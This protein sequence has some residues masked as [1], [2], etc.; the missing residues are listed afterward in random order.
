MELNNIMAEKQFDVKLGIVRTLVKE[1]EEINTAPGW[2][3]RFFQSFEELDQ[4]FK[5]WF[6]EDWRQQE[7]AKFWLRDHWNFETAEYRRHQI[8]TQGKKFRQRTEGSRRYNRNRFGPK[9]LTKKVPPETLAA[10]IKELQER[11]ITSR[12]KQ[13]AVIKEKYGISISDSSVHNLKKKYNL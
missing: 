6:G 1:I 8:H 9:Q 4:Q 7:W 13:Q 3:Y 2:K 5:I 12:R 11:G 10:F